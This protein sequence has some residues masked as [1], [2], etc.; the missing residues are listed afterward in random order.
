VCRRTEIAKRLMPD[1]ANQ[2]DRIQ[3]YGFQSAMTQKA[4]LYLPVSILLR[5]S[6][7]Q[8]LVKEIAPIQLQA[9]AQLSRAS[10]YVFPRPP[11]WAA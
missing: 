9:V 3:A 10:C 8:Q 7:R 5:F 4:R 2:L 6:A 11:C 1:F